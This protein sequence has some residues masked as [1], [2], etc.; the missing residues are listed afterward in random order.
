MSETEKKLPPTC[1]E[2]K[3]Y[4]LQHCIILFN[5]IN[6]AESAN[7]N[8]VRARSQEWKPGEHKNDRLL[9]L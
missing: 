3:K 9:R 6:N 5:W 2:G 8:I 7:I 1:N 4:T